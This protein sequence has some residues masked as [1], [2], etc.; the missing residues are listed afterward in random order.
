MVAGVG[1]GPVAGQ[2]QAVIKNITQEKF[3]PTLD[4]TEKK[5]IGCQVI[6]PEV[7]HV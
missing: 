5:T 1:S 3:A 2:W 4:A 7:I 6:F